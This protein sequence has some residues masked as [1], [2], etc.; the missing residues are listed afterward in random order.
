MPL[1]SLTIRPATAQ[2][3]PQ[4]FSLI[5]ELALYEKAPHEVTNTAA[6]LLEH[7]FQSNPP[8]FYAWV[9]EIQNTGIVGMALCYIRY[10]TWKG[11]VLYL[12]D[13]V[14]NEQYRQQGIRY[15]CDGYCC[16]EG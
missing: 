15:Y 4:I 3:V 14:V 16:Q 8:L 9:A 11:P 5:N 7:G 2:D 6:H 1:H 10:S 13:I 12:E